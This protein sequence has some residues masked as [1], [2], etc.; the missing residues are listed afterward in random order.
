M[1][2]MDGLEW[3]SREERDVAIGAGRLIDAIS[4][5]RYVDFVEL[6]EAHN[7][8]P[9]HYCGVREHVKLHFEL[10]GFIRRGRL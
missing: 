1:I 3:E 9:K 8:H 7:V 10:M 6:M 4:A 2:E 5:G